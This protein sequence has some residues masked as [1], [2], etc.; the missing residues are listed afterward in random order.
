MLLVVRGLRGFMIGRGLEIMKIIRHHKIILGSVF[1]II[2]LMIL[3]NIK[4]CNIL[5]VCN[6][7]DEGDVVLQY[8]LIH[9]DGIGLFI[10]AE[11]WN[12]EHDACGGVKN[13]YREN[14]TYFFANDNKLLNISKGD[15]IIIHWCWIPKIQDYRIRGI[16]K[17]NNSS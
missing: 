2:I 15:E 13:C 10:G 3:F 4:W 5:F 8:Q 12:C 11:H 16:R 7:Y 14:Q 17:V 1:F 6:C 9:P